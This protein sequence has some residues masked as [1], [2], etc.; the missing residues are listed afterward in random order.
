MPEGNTKRGSAKAL[1]LPSAVPAESSY[2]SNDD[3]FAAQFAQKQTSPPSRL[4]FVRPSDLRPSNEHYQGITLD[5]ECQQKKSPRQNEIHPS[6]VGKEI[7]GGKTKPQGDF[8]TPNISSIPPLQAKKKILSILSKIP[9]APPLPAR[10]KPRHTLAQK[11][12][13]GAALPTQT[14]APPIKTPTRHTRHARRQAL[15]PAAPVLPR[16]GPG[17]IVPPRRL[18][19]QPASGSRPSR[20]HPFTL[21]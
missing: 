15:A 10:G 2:V 13:F 20:L 11:A 4:W 7:K 17:R 6:L 5:L 1:S 3:R 12:T 21:P 18:H 8:I 19:P 16:P 9:L 14:L